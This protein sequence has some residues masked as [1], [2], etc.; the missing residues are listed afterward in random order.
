MTILPKRN[1]RRFEPR[2]DSA[3][4]NVGTSNQDL[5]ALNRPVQLQ[6]QVE[7]PRRTQTHNHPLNHSHGHS[8]PG[9][10]PGHL[11]QQPGHSRYS[12]TN[13]YHNLLHR[14]DSAASSASEASKWKRS[15]PLRCSNAEDHIPAKKS[16]RAHSKSKHSHHHKSKDNQSFSHCT[17]QQSTASYVG[18]RPQAAPAVTVSTSKQTL[19]PPV[20]TM[21][22]LLSPKM[23]GGAQDTF[24]KSRKAAMNDGHVSSDDDCK[25]SPPSPGGCNSEDEHAPSLQQ[26]HYSEEVSIFY[27]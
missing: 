22:T 15:P 8:Q 21:A 11:S 12:Q 7:Q 14:S 1:K 26:S 24:G 23:P 19:I 27:F 6:L 17:L 10:P 4:H 13:V 20:S 16:K 9:H 5:Q 18:L 25:S 2:D 3:Q